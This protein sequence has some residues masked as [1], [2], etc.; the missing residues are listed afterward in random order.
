ME[1]SAWMN[2]VV[3]PSYLSLVHFLLQN[4]SI[5][6]DATANFSLV[7]PSAA[8]HFTLFRVLDGGA[9]ESLCSAMSR[10]SAISTF[11]CLPL[12]STSQKL[13]MK[14]IRRRRKKERERE[15]E[16]VR[17][18]VCG[19]S[20]LC[21]KKK[22]EKIPQIW[23]D[24]IHALDFRPLA[25]FSFVFSCKTQCFLSAFGQQSSAGC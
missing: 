20:F 13:G 9:C 17:V 25:A 18:R 16:R 19:C 2:T 23:N 15:K 12:F 14:M 10:V 4:A 1:V 3:I 5:A 22:R 24:Y 21:K 6:F 11:G 7:A 8:A